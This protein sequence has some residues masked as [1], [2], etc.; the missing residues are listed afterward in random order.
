M[1]PFD[2]WKHWVDAGT[3]AAE[4]NYVIAMRMA[5][6]AGGGSLAAT[7]AQR[8]ITEKIG[9]IAAAQVA[10]GVAIATGGTLEAI[11]ASAFKPFKTRVRANRRRL[12]RARG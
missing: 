3:V 7:E 10:S 2:L 8:M 11:Y 9:A 6:L 4:A 12:H 5:R 1:N